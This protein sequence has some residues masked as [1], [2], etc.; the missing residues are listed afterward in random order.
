MQDTESPQEGGQTAA[1]TAADKIPSYPDTDEHA[2]FRRL[3][4]RRCSRRRHPRRFLADGLCV[5]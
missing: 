1:P 4:W 5:D 3:T 2:V